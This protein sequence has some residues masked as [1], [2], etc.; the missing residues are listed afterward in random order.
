MTRYGFL[1]LLMAAMAWGQ[2]ANPKTTP[3]TSQP[4][5]QNPTS[6]QP[7][8]GEAEEANVES[9]V[10]ADTPVIT[11]KG[12]CDPSASKSPALECRTEITRAEFEKVIDAVQP[13]MPARAR[14]QFANRYANILAMSIKAKDMGLDKGP[15]YEERMK[16]ARMQVLATA[17][18]REIQQK[19][20][21]IPDKDIEDYYHDNLSK[22]EQADLLRIYVPKTIQS[23]QEAKKTGDA[24]D[25]KAGDE[26]QEKH[27]K[28]SEA[29]M[30]AEADKLRARAAAGED[31]SKLQE[32][33]YQVAG[34]KSSAPNTNMGKQRRN[35]LPPSQATAFDLKPGEVSPVI[36]DQSGFFI[37]KMVSKGTMP[38]DQARDEIKGILRSERLQQQMKSVQESASPT[39]NEAY[40]GP[41]M[42]H[43]PVG[44]GGPG[45]PG[46]TPATPAKPSP[47]GTK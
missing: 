45:A 47:P 29:K 32:E 36:T 25:K 24:D 12:L 23:P 35:V 40:F 8:Q 2:A 13:N 11:I 6:S 5:G 26:E 15:D 22:F 19:A 39:L 31:F 37:Y 30:K 16:L 21:D 33:A 46:S 43:G 4:R 18:N 41:E 10:P 14:R 42:P 9:K 27:A 20:A 28:D 38:L 3:V 34:L 1:C 7:P 17:L 44:P